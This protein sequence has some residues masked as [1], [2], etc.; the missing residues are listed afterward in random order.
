MSTAP[1][2][3]SPLL[4][5]GGADQDIVT[6]KGRRQVSGATDL[7][8][9][10]GEKAQFDELHLDPRFLKQPGRPDFG[11]YR[12]VLNVITDPDQNREVLIILRKLLRDFP[13]RVLNRSDDV[14]HSTRDE[15]ARLLAGIA[16]LRVPKAIRVRGNKPKVAAGAVDK[17]GLEFPIILRVAGTHMGDI[18]GLVRDMGEL[19]AALIADG[20]HILTEYVDFRS[21]DG[22]YRKYRVYF[23]G[24]RMILRHMIVSDAWNIHVRDRAR[25]MA[26]KPAL[27]AEENTMFAQAEGAFPAAVHDVLRA[28]RARM[29]LDFFGIDFGITP[30]GEAV[31]FE[32]NA[33]MSFFPLFTDPRFAYVEQCLAPARAAFREMVREALRSGS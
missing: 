30:A 7:W 14:L 15:V 33:T 17:A 27:M 24:E 26:D 19:Q 1:A 2:A 13:G 20:Q 5:V 3:R 32:A 23:F 25:F 6:E 28:M 29:T 11:P 31:L 16:G 12:C 9:L 21:G 18:V 8:R 10:L 22:L 4:L